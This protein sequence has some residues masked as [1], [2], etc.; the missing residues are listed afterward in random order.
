MNSSEQKVFQESMKTTVDLF[1][2][3][4]RAEDWSRN[5]IEG[6]Q[7]LTTGEQWKHYYAW[8]SNPTS[9]DEDEV[10][11]LAVVGDTVPTNLEEYPESLKVDTFQNGKET[12]FLVTHRNQDD[13]KSGE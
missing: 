7:K 1:K 3:R 10:N 6:S 13:E 9:Y 11:Q 12:L 4:N 5:L 2:R 8:L